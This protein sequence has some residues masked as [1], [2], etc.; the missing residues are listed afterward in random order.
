[1]KQ[2]IFSPGGVSGLPGLPA[3]SGRAREEN[4]SSAEG[5]NGGQA[6]PR[7]CFSSIFAA[8]PPQLPKGSP[9]PWPAASSC[10]LALA[11]PVIADSHGG[12][13]SGPVRLHCP[14]ICSPTFRIDPPQMT[15]QAAPHRAL[16]AHVWVEDKQ[17]QRSAHRLWSRVAEGQLGE[18]GGWQPKG[19]ILVTSS[20]RSQ[21]L[22]S[23]SPVSAATAPPP[24][25][26]GVLQRPVLL[27]LCSE[28][29]FL[30]CCSDQHPWIVA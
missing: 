8:P 19:M 17:P 11:C 7:T 24:L 9:P 23:R 27:P 18:E 25:L 5:A 14:A 16:C 21:S 28:M 12:G 4:A 2:S 6:L 26:S 15:R 20:Y 3:G 22:E 30:A 1:M 13:G 29:P 10:A